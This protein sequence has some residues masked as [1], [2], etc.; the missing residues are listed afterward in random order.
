M[1]W[2]GMNEPSPSRS[3]MTWTCPEH[4]APAPMPMVGMRQ[5]L[6]DRRRQLLGHQLQDHRERTR[7][8]DR[9]RIRDEPACLVA[10][11]ALDPGLAAHAVLGLGRPADVAHDRD[12]RLHER[13]D[14]G[15][16]SAPRPPP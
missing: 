6:R 10:V 11:L 15:R 8:L 14:D 12:A 2:R 5:A 7:L 13:L 3:V 9:E 16:A 1:A 4:P